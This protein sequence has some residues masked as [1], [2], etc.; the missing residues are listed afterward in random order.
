MR[1][2]RVILPTLAAILATAGDGLANPIPPRVVL[3]QR[4]E[5]LEAHRASSEDKL[6]LADH[7]RFSNLRDDDSATCALFAAYVDT[8]VPACLE[9][10]R[11]Y[12]RPCFRFHRWFREHA[13]RPSQK[14]MHAAVRTNL[15]LVLE[16][17]R[18][19]MQTRLPGQSVGRPTR[20]FAEAVAFA[21]IAADYGDSSSVPA[22]TELRNLVD[23]VPLFLLPSDALEEIPRF[24]TMALRRIA[25]PDSGSVLRPLDASRLRFCRTIADAD[26]VLIRRGQDEAW[27]PLPAGARSDPRLAAL[28][29]GC[30]LSQHPLPVEAPEA[31]GQIAMRIAFADGAAATFVPLAGGRLIYWDN[32]RLEQQYPQIASIDLCHWVMDVARVPPR[33]ATSRSP[34]P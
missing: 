17:V 5:R 20:L 24:L 25:D 32:V 16:E 18:H 3:R 19:S 14:S 34:S 10:E 31:A 8:L 12:P 27:K 30:V 1:W 21:E 13:D 4:L 22:I 11:D 6:K 7:L 26:S 29:N 9:R 2:W 28:L 15:E 33:S 23:E